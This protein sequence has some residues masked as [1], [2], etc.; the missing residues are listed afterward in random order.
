[1][2]G[3]HGRSARSAGSKGDAAHIQPA[4]IASRALVQRAGFTREGF[5]PR[6]LKIGGRWCDHDRW[7]I[8]ADQWKAQRPLRRSRA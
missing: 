4:N 8:N 3:M 6:Y 2:T 5:S 7:A 1:M